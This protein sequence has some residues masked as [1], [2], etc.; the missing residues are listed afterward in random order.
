MLKVYNLSDLDPEQIR[1]LCTRNA[2]GN[3][4]IRS[5]VEDIIEEVK[6]KG[7]KAL[8]SFTEKFDGIKLDKLYIGK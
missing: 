3:N 4:N 8:K 6:L 2:D 5:V 1:E 7:D